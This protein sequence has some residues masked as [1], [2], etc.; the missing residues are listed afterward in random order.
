MTDINPEI[1][2]ANEPLVQPRKAKQETQDKP[3]NSKNT[4]IQS[5]DDNIHSEESAPPNPGL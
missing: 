5:E 2:D 3:R 1:E 4:L